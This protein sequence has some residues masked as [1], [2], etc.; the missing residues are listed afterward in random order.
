MLS[1]S[2]ADPSPAVVYRR[3]KNSRYLPLS[4]TGSSDGTPQS[5]NFSDFGTFNVPDEAAAKRDGAHRPAK[6]DIWTDT[7]GFQPVPWGRSII[8]DNSQCETNKTFVV[9]S[10]DGAS[11]VLNYTGVNSLVTL[12]TALPITVTISTEEA[13]TARS[14]PTDVTTVQYFDVGYLTYK[15]DNGTNLPTFTADLASD[16]FRCSSTD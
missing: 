11:N 4:Y 15:F 3:P 10:T 5:L 9:Q 8:L 2:V 7:D 14:F 13:P 1:G 12:P 6:R 16:I